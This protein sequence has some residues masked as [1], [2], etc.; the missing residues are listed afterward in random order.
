MPGGGEFHR[1]RGLSRRPHGGDWLYRLDDVERVAG[2]PRRL[3][4]R[5]PGPE[6]RKDDL[7]R[8]WLATRVV[9]TKFKD[10]GL[11]CHHAKL[12]SLPLTSK[13]WS[14]QRDRYW[15]ESDVQAYLK[16][17][18]EAAT[19]P[20]L[21]DQPVTPAAA[22]PAAP[23][24]TP[25]V[26]AK[27]A[28]VPPAKKRQYLPPFDYTAAVAREK[29]KDANL[30]M[31][32]VARWSVRQKSNLSRFLCRGRGLPADVGFVHPRRHRDGRTAGKGRGAAVA[33]NRQDEEGRGS[34][35]G[36]KRLIERD[37]KLDT[38]THK[39]LVKQGFLV[40][41]SGHLLDAARRAEAASGGP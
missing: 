16:R 20:K 40:L 30:S 34:R 31:R 4:G 12:R 10:A 33:Q 17:Q 32:K 28:V 26:E 18:A 13:R 5:Q 38:C 1:R 8:N 15:L 7:G 25:V 2:E 27:A 23:A 21:P 11:K 36:P 6:K 39:T 9:L 22:A 19:P 14:N 37:T 24:V 29:M 3:H 35:W 41:E